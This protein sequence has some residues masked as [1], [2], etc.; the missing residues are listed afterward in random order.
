[1]C[2]AER[3]CNWNACNDQ[4]SKRQPVTGG[5]MVDK[6]GP[7]NRIQAA[8]SKPIFKSAICSEMLARNASQKFAADDL[9]RDVLKSRL[10][11]PVSKRACLADPRDHSLL[12]ELTG[13]APG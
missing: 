4:V 3:V 8:S 2:D 12:L 10:R 13:G 7:P 5:S 1:M 6:S 11:R 9:A